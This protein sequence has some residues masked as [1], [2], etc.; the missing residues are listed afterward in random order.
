MVY[1]HMQMREQGITAFAA[2]P[3]LLQSWLAAGLSTKRVPSLTWLLTGAEAMSPELLQRLR[4]A[5]PRTPIYFG[6]GPTEASEKVSL[7]IYYPQQALEPTVLVG[8]AIPNVEIY[9]LDGQ[10]RPVPMGV[11]GELCC[12]GVNLAKGYHG[13]SDLTAE[14]FVD[15][16]LAKGDT[17]WLR[18]MYRTGDLA[19]LAEDGRIQ[20]LGRLDRQVNPF[21]S[22]PP[23]SDSCLHHQEAHSMLQLCARQLSPV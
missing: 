20:I 1:V 6:Y 5:F 17:P 9:I 4:E 13:R 22:G 11:A 7:Q 10:L 18:R 23:M 21:H 3:T 19:Q 16:P 8:H 12:S 14:A 2:V 15:N